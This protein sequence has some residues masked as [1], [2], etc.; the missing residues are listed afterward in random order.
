MSAGNLSQA[1]HDPSES[2]DIAPVPATESQADL[3]AV[4][5]EVYRV[6]ARRLSF[7]P[8][9][10]GRDTVAEVIRSAVA[11]LV[12]RLSGNRADTIRRD[13]R[14]ELQRIFSGMLGSHGDN[15]GPA[16]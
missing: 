16:D 7:D 1:E 11:E 2:L 15:F 3:E 10:F 5:R 8:E 6:E 14:S 13:L 9:A 12:T 4:A